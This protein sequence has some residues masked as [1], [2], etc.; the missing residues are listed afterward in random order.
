[1]KKET[2]AWVRK[3]EN[4]YQA[5]AQLAEGRGAFPDQLCFLCQQA[6]EKYLKALLQELAQSIPKT[7][8]LDYLRGLLQPF[9]PQLRRL[10]RGFV[11]LTDFAV[12]T[13]YPG[14]TA[15][16]RQAVAALRWCS[17]VR[18]A[19]RLLLGILPP[20]RKRPKAP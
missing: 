14:D 9:H 6:S 20:R 8:D 4:D 7:H 11:F 1:M 16:K 10:R 17:R 3:A 13:R 18:E 5:A 12:D 19:C 2:R 15:S